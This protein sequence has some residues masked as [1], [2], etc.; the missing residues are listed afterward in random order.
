MKQGAVNTPASRHRGVKRT[1]RAS[2]RLWTTATLWQTIST[3]VNIQAFWF[4]I[5]PRQ[6]NSSTISAITCYRSF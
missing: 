4:H 1:S 6:T 5:F 3:A 2:T